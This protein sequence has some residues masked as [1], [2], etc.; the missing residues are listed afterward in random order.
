M[1][2]EKVTYYDYLE[3]KLNKEEYQQNL[4]YLEIIDIL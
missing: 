4:K 1:S 2:G 3:A